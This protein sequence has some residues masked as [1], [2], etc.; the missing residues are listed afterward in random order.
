MAYQMKKVHCKYSLII[1]EPS[2]FEDLADCEPDGWLNGSFVKRFHS[3][4]NNI[5]FLLHLNF[6]VFF[7]KYFPH[8]TH[9]KLIQVFHCASNSHWFAYPYATKFK[10]LTNVQHTLLIKRFLLL[11]LTFIVYTLNI[12]QNYQYLKISK[13]NIPPSL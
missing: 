2:Y 10:S 12:N 9:T 1:E 6:S 5:F 13:K 7:I 3:D 8:Y 11:V 4:I